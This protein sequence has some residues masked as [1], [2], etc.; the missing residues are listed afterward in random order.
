MK[1]PKRITYLKF[2]VGNRMNRKSGKFEPTFSVVAVPTSDA[3]KNVYL[4]RIDLDAV[5]GVPGL[6]GECMDHRTVTRLEEEFGHPVI[7]AD[8][9]PTVAFLVDRV[10]R[11]GVATHCIRYVRPR[12]DT[13]DINDFDTPGGKAKL[14]KAGRAEKIISFLAPTGRRKQFGQKGENRK[15]WKNEKRDR[16]GELNR[17]KTMGAFARLCKANP[18]FE[19]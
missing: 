7:F 12:T 4:Q 18:E 17:K 9:R 15:S 5:N 1:T 6:V 10:N 2:F 3:K 13:Q 19:K 14:L 8:I 16:V 11:Q